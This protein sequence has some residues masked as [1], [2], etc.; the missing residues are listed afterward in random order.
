MI[1]VEDDDESKSPLLMSENESSS[2]KVIYAR[3]E[4]AAETT[5]EIDEETGLSDDNDNQGSRCDKDDD[6]ASKIPSDEGE[7]FLTSHFAGPFSRFYF[8]YSTYSARNPRHC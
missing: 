5:M 1:T 2:A 3:N 4:S 6:M 8:F 7:A